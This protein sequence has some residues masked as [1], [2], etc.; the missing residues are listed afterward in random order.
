[1]KFSI[2]LPVKNGGH[3]LKDCVASILAQSFRDFNLI[4]LDNRSTDGTLEWLKS[5]NDSRIVIHESDQSLSI[6]ENWGRIKDVPKNEFITL[7]G[8][9]DLLDPDYLE[10]MNAL[11]GRHPEA[12][13]Y[14]AH[15]QYIDKDGLVIRDCLPMDE[16]QYG[17][18]YLACFLCRTIDSTGT[19]YMMRSKDYDRLHGINPAFDN[20]IFADYALWLDMTLLNYKATAMNTTFKYRVHKSVSRVTGA[21]KYTDAFEKFLIFLKEHADKNDKI[22]LVME[23]YGKTM[24]LFYCESLSHRLLKTPR[25]ERDLLA[26]DFITICKKYA[27]L[28]FPGETFEPEKEFRINIAK[29]LDNTAP[30]RALFGIANTILKKLQ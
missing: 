4:V 11:I 1:M 3:Y 25:K 12:S 5:L 24:L 29:L 14:Q 21:Q 17:H 22:K 18:E 19:G 20:L 9:D 30:G 27:T 26:N 10:T 2:I 23:R 6:E 15:F 8:H 7:I 28:F 16:I 13:L